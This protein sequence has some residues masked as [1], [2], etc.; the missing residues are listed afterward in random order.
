MFEPLEITN[1]YILL[2]YMGGDE[3]AALAPAEYTKKQYAADC[4]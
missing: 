4:D 3:N 1:G 2:K